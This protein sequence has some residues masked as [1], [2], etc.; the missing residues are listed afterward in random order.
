MLKI[1]EEHEYIS[2]IQKWQCQQRGKACALRTYLHFSTCWIIKLLSFQKRGWGRRHR[3][4][5]KMIMYSGINII[6][7][8]KTYH[9]NEQRGGE[10]RWKDLKAESWVTI[11]AVNPKETTES[12]KQKVKA[13]MLTKD[14]WKKH[15][16]T[17]IKSQR[18]RKIRGRG[19]KY[20]WVRQKMN[21]WS[22]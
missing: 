5:E 3:K 12:T 8:I 7:R 21:T 15:K 9:N 18:S 16:G 6:Y 17:S 11:C 13:D 19:T 4:R 2:K 20:T 22:F 10:R 14:M 1:L